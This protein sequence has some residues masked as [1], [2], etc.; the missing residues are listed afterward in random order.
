MPMIGFLPLPAGDDP[1]TGFPTSGLLALYKCDELT[2]STLSDATGNLPDLT[3]ASGIALDCATQTQYIVDAT[4]LRAEVV[5][6]PATAAFAFELYTPALATGTT[7]VLLGAVGTSLSQAPG[8]R[9]YLTQTASFGYATDRYTISVTGRLILDGGSSTAYTISLGTADFDGLV[10]ETHYQI[11]GS[12]VCKV[13][14]TPTL[15]L[16]IRSGTSGP[17]KHYTD[18]IAGTAT[19]SAVFADGA[20]SVAYRVAAE[21]TATNPFKGKL[22]TA[23]FALGE[24]DLDDVRDALL[25]VNKTVAQQKLGTVA[26]YWQFGKGSGTNADEFFTDVTAAITGTEA[27]STGLS[28]C[29]Q[30]CLGQGQGGGG[31]RGII[32]GGEASFAAGALVATSTAMA[33]PILQGTDGWTLIAAL[34]VGDNLPAAERTLVSLYGP[35]STGSEETDATLLPGIHISYNASGFITGRVKR[36]A[37]ADI[38]AGTT[39]NLG[40]GNRYSSNGV[41]TVYAISC[42]STGALAARRIGVYDDDVTEEATAAANVANLLNRGVRIRIGDAALDC[43]LIAGPVGLYSRKLT[44]SEILQWRTQA[45]RMAGRSTWVDADAATPGNGTERFPYASFQ[46]ALRVNQPTGTIYLNGGAANQRIDSIYSA[47]DPLKPASL[48][49][50]TLIGTNDPVIVSDLGESDKYPL[51]LDENA[52]GTWSFTGITFDATDAGVDNGPGFTDGATAGAAVI[53][54]GITRLEMTNCTTKNAVKSS[55]SNGTGLTSRAIENIITGH[56][57][58]DNEE[59]AVYFRIAAS[60]PVGARTLQVVD[61]T[62]SGNGEDGIKTSNEFSD[63]SDGGGTPASRSAIYYENILLDQIHITGGKNQISL[64]GCSGGTVTNFLCEG[65]D[66]VGATT[67]GLALGGASG[68]MITSDLVIANGTIRDYGTTQGY[69]VKNANSTGCVAINVVTGNCFADLIDTGG[70]LTSSYCSGDSGHATDL[71][72]TGGSNTPAATITFDAADDA[73]IS[74]GDGFEDGQNL[75]TNYSIL[76][77]DLA[78]DARPEEGAWNR[79]AY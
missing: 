79:G 38:T 34:R 67:A 18:V 72:P 70:T 63:G 58:Q 2:G 77:T 11:Y 21:G 66:A 24:P 53:L 62:A 10:P 74:S 30:L 65:A 49:G 51:Y 8:L 20:S 56:T 76:R 28:G 4:G 44:D 78:G 9:I 61:F 69:A 42:D 25:S 17:W 57:S 46:S 7:Q 16:Y 55:P 45:L 14:T 48:A 6:Q 37:I 47:S 27:W 39:I 50:M 52:T 3:P 12:F 22:I 40:A 59:H 15:S 26:R 75:W 43:D 31:K 41:F 73:H 32:L 23:L 68:Y 13:G 64:Q 1:L 29:T 5:G 35:L 36:R 60:S 19:T 71:W 33:T 54:D